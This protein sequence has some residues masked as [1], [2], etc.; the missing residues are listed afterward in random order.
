[1]HNEVSFQKRYNLFNKNVCT[2]SYGTLK[3]SY[4]NLGCEC[5]GKSKI[6]FSGI[7]IETCILAKLQVSSTCLNSYCHAM[8]EEARVSQKTCLK[9]HMEREAY[10]KELL[11]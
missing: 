2:Q 11:G 8:L 3:I 9:A 5:R 10:W 1:M 6:I 7:F 4:R